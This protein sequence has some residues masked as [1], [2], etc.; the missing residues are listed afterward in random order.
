MTE[1]KAKVFIAS[2]VEGLDI[3][4]ALQENLEHS[5]EMT[6]W[7]QGVFDLSEY[8]LDELVNEL[9]RFDF[10][11]F[12]FS[13]EDLSKIR[14]EEIRTTRDNVIFELGL[15]IGRIGRQRCYVI[16]P[17]SADKL[18]LPTDLLGIKPATYSPERSDK[19]IQAALG[20]ACNQMRRLIKKHGVRK[21]E[22]SIVSV[23][24]LQQI[25]AA[26]LTALYQSRDDYG[27]YRRDASSIDRYVSTAEESIHMVSINLMTGLPFHGLC[28][29]LK[30]KLNNKNNS[31]SVVI[32]LLNPWNM[33]LMKA[34]SPVLDI[35][36]NKL[37]ESILDTLK[38]L[39]TL[40]GELS[41][42]ARGR[43]TIL[44]HNAIPFG[45]AI[46][47]DVFS[48]KG[49]IQIETKPYKAPLRKSI[50][51][52]VTDTGSSEIF[53]N[54]KDG[55]CKLLDDAQ[56]YDTLVVYPERRT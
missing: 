33:N 10:A 1:D 37:S 21:K 13:F 17:R 47:L 56:D 55:Y 19:N 6:V 43:F 5:A 11:I 2:S 18:H 48:G 26:G 38:E 20:P 27:K 4:Y 16:M 42:E 24:V 15:F 32:S 29:A 45:S 22:H 31:F 34:L 30:A 46:M 50:A 41:S 3:A 39:S 54:L 49:R 35:K 8:T 9:D 44:V 12:V 25:S 36:P 52:E 23:D 14:D 28:S 7:S 40:R 53:S 51:F